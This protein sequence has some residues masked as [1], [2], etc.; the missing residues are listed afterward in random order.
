M[1]LPG[2]AWLEHEITVVQDY[3]TVRQTAI[4]NPVGLSGLVYLYALCTFYRLIFT[5]MLKALARTA[6]AKRGHR[7]EQQFQETLVF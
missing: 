3:A 5:A 2:R 1:R 4:F 6:E 7:L